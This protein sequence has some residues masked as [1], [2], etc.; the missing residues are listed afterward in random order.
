MS[1]KK[2]AVSYSFLPKL[3]KRI[4]SGG[5]ATR[6]DAER[7]VSLRNQQDIFMLAA[8]YGLLQPLE[9]LATISLCRFRLPDREISICGG[10]E[11][12]LRTL[13]PMM[14]IAGASG[15]MIGNYL[16][17]SGRDP[18]AD[19]QEITDLGLSIELMP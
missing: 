8:R 1:T 6:R 19:V 10:R 12:G 18:A 16:T 7:I 17:T 9:I 14:Y 13:Q 2:T 15:T 4:L 3:T 11:T 5:A